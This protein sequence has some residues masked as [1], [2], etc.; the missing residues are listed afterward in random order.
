MYLFIYVLVH[1]AYYVVYYYVCYVSCVNLE[2][3]AR[4][5]FEAGGVGLCIGDASGPMRMLLCR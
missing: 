2:A 3:C 4:N 5:P 1:D